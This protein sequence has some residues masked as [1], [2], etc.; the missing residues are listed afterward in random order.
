MIFDPF[1]RF[2][3]IDVPRAYGSIRGTSQ[4]GQVGGGKTAAHPHVGAF[5]GRGAVRRGGSGGDTRGY[6]EAQR[7][8]NFDVCWRSL[9]GRGSAGATRGWLAGRFR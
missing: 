9:H 4:M 7:I 6:G 2:S 8:E 5:S 3:I 1:D